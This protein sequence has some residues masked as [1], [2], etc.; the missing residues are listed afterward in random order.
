MNRDT[1]KTATHKTHCI[2]P[3]HFQPEVDVRVDRTSSCCDIR[4]SNTRQR[5]RREERQEE[6]DFLSLP[7]LCP[8]FPLLF[9]FSSSLLPG[10]KTH[11]TEAQF[12]LTFWYLSSLSSFRGKWDDRLSG[13]KFPWNSRY[14]EGKSAKRKEK[15]NLL[16]AHRALIH[17]T[18]PSVHS[19]DSSR[20]NFSPP[21]SWILFNPG[22]APARAITIPAST[23]RGCG[24]SGGGV[25]RL[26]R[27]NCEPHCFSVLCNWLAAAGPVG[28]RLTKL[29]NNEPAGKQYLDDSTA[30]SLPFPFRPPST[31]YIAPPLPVF[32]YSARK[33]VEKNTARREGCL[34][35]CIWLRDD[36]FLVTKHP[37]QLHFDSFW[38]IVASSSAVFDPGQSKRLN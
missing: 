25:S 4:Q 17:S 23:W 35:K 9:F 32:R 26:W 20:D 24:S 31:D 28:G 30:R 7:R 33:G 29:E 11:L 5:S 1:R 34:V 18:F 15:K 13:Q 12:I 27:S 14:W 37:S 22:D 16:D 21:P 6:T 3:R 10:Q 8:F 19:I 2:I 36:I 38:L